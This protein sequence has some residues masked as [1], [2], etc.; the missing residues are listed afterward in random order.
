MA[1]LVRPSSKKIVDAAGRLVLEWD[2][3]FSALLNAVST[4]SF[5]VATVPDAADVGIGSVIYVSNGAA[6]QPVLAFSDGTDWL[7]VDDR[8]PISP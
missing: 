3:F 5:T 4:Q 2:A 8:N 6:G 7:R 1:G